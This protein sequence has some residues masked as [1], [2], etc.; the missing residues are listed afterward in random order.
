MDPNHHL[1]N[2][3]AI[4]EGWFL[5]SVCDSPP[6]LTDALPFFQLI[7]NAPAPAIPVLDAQKG[8]KPSKR[9]KI[10]HYQAPSS[11][12]SAAQLW[13]GYQGTAPL[14][15]PN[16]TNNPTTLLYAQLSSL[17]TSWDPTW[18]PHQ[19]RADSC[20]QTIYLSILIQNTAISYP[21]HPPLHLLLRL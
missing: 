6:T 18:L 13:Q 12:L 2:P 3:G 20:A 8:A 9:P 4:P 15:P 11:G 16:G 10:E 5:G 19:N 7:G 21:D 1:S 14:T 17:V